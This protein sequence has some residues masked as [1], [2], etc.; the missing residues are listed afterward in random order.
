MGLFSSGSVHAY[1]DHLYALLEFAEQ[2]KLERVMLHLFTDGRDAPRDEGVK[3][4]AGLQERITVKYPHA[5]IVSIIGRSFAMD[6]DGNWDRT[7]RTYNLLSGTQG[8][9]FSNPIVYVGESYKKGVWDEFVEPG[10]LADE[11]GAA[12]GRIRDGDALIYFDFREDSTRQLTSAFAMDEFSH[13][14]RKKIQNLFFVTMTE[15]DA[16]F[17]VSVAFPPIEIEWPLSRIIADAM[18]T[19]LH[20]AETEKYAHV[21]YFFN[22][23]KEQQFPKEERVLIPS[24][25]RKDLALHP[26]MAAESITNTVVD[27]I[28]TYSF[29][30]V[31]F[32][33]GDMVGHTGDFNA[34]SRALEVLDA[35][36]ARLRDAIL[37]KGG[38]LVITADHG[39]AEEKRYVASGEPRTK[40][41]TNAVPLYVVG[42]DFRRKDARTPEEIRACYKDTS[43]MLT[44]VA[45]TILELMGLEQPPE[46]TGVSLLEKYRQQK[47][48]EAGG[49][50]IFSISRFFS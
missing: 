28:H 45:P 14:E 8:A 16:S 32:A 33:N 41:T 9:P 13:F 39:N 10:Y 31:N 43:G 24:S 37:E 11:K 34:T 44:D 20:V 50:S 15:Y 17:P 36:L 40:H 12:V 35:S 18:L 25:H 47:P 38:V 19:Q 27:A 5:K 1:V 6:R 42:N 30:L 7:E 29:I 49:K 46:M 2:Q 4:L 48:A 3:F 26:E 23:G 22:G 21:T